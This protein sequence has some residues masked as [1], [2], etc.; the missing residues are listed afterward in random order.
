M[1]ESRILLNN[2]AVV[3]S[4]FRE[5]D[6]AFT[7]CFRYEDMSDPGQAGRVARFIAPTDYVAERL[8]K[9]MLENV[10][11]RPGGQQQKQV[12]LGLVWVVGGVAACRC[13]ASLGVM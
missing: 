3:E 1:R 11:P 6:P 10:R 13:S 9:K 5:L 7:A 12:R 2:A 8:E 4:I